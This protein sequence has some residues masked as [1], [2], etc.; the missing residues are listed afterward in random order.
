MI[1][2]AAAASVVLLAIGVPVAAGTVARTDAVQADARLTLDR[3]GGPPVAGQGFVLTTAIESLPVPG[4][5]FSFVLTVS[6]PERVSFLRSNPGFPAAIPCE[7]AGQTV[8]CRGRHLGGDLTASVSL[9]LRA[10]TAG[11]YELRGALRLEGEADADETNNTALLEVTV[12]AAPAAQRCIV[13]RLRGKTLAQ[14]RRAITTARCRLGTTS[15]RYDPRL[16]RGLV[17][18]QRP[19]ARARVAAG[20]RVALVLSRGPR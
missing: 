9:T 6:L 14:A 11:T 10:A 16:R 4:P 15:S 17:L 18:S 8:T 5:P 3:G 20:T 7:A 2:S 12:A 1:R 19:A 13:P